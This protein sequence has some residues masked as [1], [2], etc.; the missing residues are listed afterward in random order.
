MAI[1]IQEASDADIP[2]FVETEIAAYSATP[3]ASG[4]ILFPGPFPADGLQKRVQQ[5]IDSRKEVASKFMMA[6]DEATGEQMA[7]SKWCFYETEED[8]KS[9]PSR[10][11]PSGQGIN[12]EACQ[13]FYGAVIENKEQIIGS[14][15]HVCQ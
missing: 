11:I 7:F 10:A 13:A 6:I 8:I 1:I 15:P 12:T 4:S 9:A 14:S 2:R 3:S 5:T